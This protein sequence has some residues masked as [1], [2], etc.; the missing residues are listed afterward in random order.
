M[1]CFL[2][3]KTVVFVISSSGSS[4]L[5]K[6]LG[7]LWCK[8]SSSM[9]L[10]VLI[11]LFLKCTFSSFEVIFCYLWH[12]SSSSFMKYCTI[13]GKMLFCHWQNYPQF[14]IQWF[15]S[16]NIFFWLNPSSPLTFLTFMMHFIPIKDIFCL[17]WRNAFQPLIEFSTLYSMT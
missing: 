1:I 13:Y 12:K 2:A 9:G 14:M 5:I 8:A 7:H 17:L 16:I 6:L 15:L 11:L 3:I 4:Q 10:L